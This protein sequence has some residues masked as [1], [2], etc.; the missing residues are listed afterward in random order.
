MVP[1]YSEFCES[2]LVEGDACQIARTDIEFTSSPTEAGNRIIM[3]TRQGK[4][5]YPSSEIPLFELSSSQ[6]HVMGLEL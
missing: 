6:R 4:S 1:G 2:V 3:V 5:S